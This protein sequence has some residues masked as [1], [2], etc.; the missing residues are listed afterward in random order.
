MIVVDSDLKI[1]NGKIKSYSQNYVKHLTKPIFLVNAGDVFFDINY[2]SVFID[3]VYSNIDEEYYKYVIDNFIDKIN[4]KLLKY[5][6]SIV[7]YEANIDRVKR[8]I[9]IKLVFSNGDVIET[10]I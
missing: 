3:V 5:N 4:N 1:E 6:V 7:D 9:D 8:F 10:K 2:G